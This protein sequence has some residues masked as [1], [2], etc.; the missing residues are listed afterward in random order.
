MLVIGYGKYFDGNGVNGKSSEL[1]PS[2]NSTCML[3]AELRSLSR[4]SRKKKRLDSCN[5]EEFTCD[6]RFM[7]L[8]AFP[9]TELLRFA[10]TDVDVQ[11]PAAVGVIAA[12][13]DGYLRYESL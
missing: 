8:S 5:D 2:L 13:S 3:L 10:W 7:S 1:N 12:C 9:L 11:P 4:R 6:V